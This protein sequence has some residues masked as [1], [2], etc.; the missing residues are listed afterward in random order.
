A[1]GW[2]G[3]INLLSG[4]TPN[5]VELGITVKG[6]L[7]AAGMTVAVT[8][9]PTADLISR[10]ITDKNYDITTWSLNVLPE[11]PWSGIDRNLRSDSPTIRNGYADPNFDAA[12]AE[13]RKATTVEQKKTALA[14]VQKV[15]NATYPGVMYQQDEQYLTWGDKVHGVKL[16]REG[17]AMFDDVD[18][19]KGPHAE[20]DDRP[21]TRGR[22]HPRP[23]RHTAA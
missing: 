19:D 20:A 11:A 22:S 15:W 12:L 2:N 16:T 8:N 6:L 13:L 14:D 9:V 1:A 5:G 7:E 23:S 3:N 17:V 4:D 21:G 10:V 18:L